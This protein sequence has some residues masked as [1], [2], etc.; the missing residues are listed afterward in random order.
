[1]LHLLIKLTRVG[2]VIFWVAAVLSLAGVIPAP[3]GTV[4]AWAAAVVL[5]I[6]L[7]EYVLV[8]P[9]IAKLEGKEISFVR[10]LVFGFTHWLPVVKGDR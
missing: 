9:R 6:H 8:K 1:M 5:L 3:T 10:T 4:I 7:V 2:V